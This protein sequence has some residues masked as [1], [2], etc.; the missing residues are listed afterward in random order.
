MA[1]EHWMYLC[2]GINITL[3]G[4]P[5]EAQSGGAACGGEQFA[6][7]DASRCVPAAW[8]CDM[9]PQCP[10]ASDEIGC[11]YNMTCGAGQFRCVR[12]GLCIAASWR[13]DGD[14]D[15]GPHDASDEDPYMCEKDFKCW[16]KWARCATPEDGHFNCVPVYHFCDGVRHCLDGSDEWD[17]CDNFTEASCASHGCS[18]CR[19]THEGVACYCQPGYEW[20]NG[21]CVDSDEC[22]WEGACSQRCTNLPGSYTC[23]CVDGYT[24]RDDKKSCAAINEP[25]G[26]PLSLVVATQSGVERAWPAGGAPRNRSLDALG[27]RALDFHF[28]NRTV[29]YIHHNISRSSLV[30]VDADNFNNRTVMPSPTLFPDLNSVSHL[31]VDWVANNWYFADEAREV[32]Y[33]CDASLRFCRMLLDAG[34]SKLRGLALDPA[35]GLMFWSV[36]GAAA[37]GVW[38]ATLGG[39]A[40]RSLAALKLVYPGALAVD[41]AARLLYWVDAYLESVERTDYDGGRR[42]TVRRSYVTQKLQQISVLESTLYLPV[43]SNSS[44]AAVSRYGR[45]RRRSSVP[46]RARPLAAL[47]YHRQRQPLVSHPCAAHKGGCAHVCVTA[48]R[49]DGRDGRDGRAPHAQCLCRHGFRLVGHGDCERV[50]SDSFLVVSRGAPALVSGLLL[51][52]RGALHD[53]P[54]APA[55]HAARP[56]VADVDLRDRT[57]YYCDVHRYE[58][59]RQKLD[60]S[61]REVFV[62]DDVDNCEGLAIDWMGRNVYWTDDALGQVSV[63][64][65]DAPA[66]RVLLREQNFNPR[67]IAL[68]P[69]NG[70][71]YWSVWASVQGARARLEVAAMDASR[72]RTLLDGE[73]HWPNGL[74]LL[75]PERVLYWCDTYL[76]KIER[77]LVTAA[78]ELAPGARREL[79]AHEKPDF[80]LFKPYGLAVYEDAVVWSEHGT[81]QVRRLRV[82][83]SVDTLRAFPPPLY[84]LRRVSAAAR[85]GANLCSQDNGGCAELC[86]A[87]GAGARRCACA[88]G[89]AL[90]PDGRACRAAPAATRAPAC[91]DKHFHCGHGRC[92]DSSFLCDGDADCPDGADEDASPTGPCANV[93]CKGDEFMQCGMRCIPK[94]WVCDGL[95]DCA[96]GADEAAGACARAACGAAQFACAR[97]RRCLPAAWRCDGAPD[98]GRHDDSDEAGCETESCG[99][100]SFRC[101]NGACV[102]WEFYCD[103]HA[104]CADASDERACPSTPATPPRRPAHAHRHNDTEKLGLCEDH[105][106]QCDNR[107]CI[108]KEFRCD[109]RVDCLDG[110]DE[111]SC[112]SAH[113][114]GAPAAG[115]AP[116]ADDCAAPALRCDNDS[117]CVP[118]LQLCDGRQD[119]ADGADEADRCELVLRQLI[120]HFKISEAQMGSWVELPLCLR[121]FRQTLPLITKGTCADVIRACLK[122]SP[123]WI[124]I[125]TLNLKTNMRAHL[126]ENYDSDFSQQLFELGEGKTSFPN[127]DCSTADIE[128]DG[129]LGRIIYTLEHLIDAI[130]PGLE[131]LLQKGYR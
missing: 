65:L 63:A 32:V 110:S 41:P 5:G 117:R 71:M 81:G 52:G 44:V 131:S 7:A 29:C 62:G 119:C 74:A 93:T 75:L 35:A 97:S 107:E 40:T 16:G 15:C 51:G 69:A 124:S 78:G 72:R 76:N 82:N 34:L 49:G 114:T 30:C 100:G 99:S 122:S 37:P 47:V 45:E 79:V 48:Y 94:S 121:D 12:S 90:A 96:D 64:R 95:K 86:L 129:R 14:A 111:W 92:I 116:R 115:S 88:E 123:L 39:D 20:R 120:K 50:E 70:V 11:T 46:M 67:S 126:S 3:L 127:T 104:D 9:R 2:Y 22:E 55:A 25:V 61:E 84:D 24:L 108:R 60:G 53:E 118:L 98:C 8:R 28:S 113:T 80:P 83:G 73:L 18:A 105:E 33:A 1:L 106:F 21:H 112:D 27:V 36:W 128:L 66:R 87:T 4:V 109:S 26:A 103:G 57:L 23:A 31:A 19:P 56:T 17:I 91:P 38:R 59:V 85:T 101:A 77:V 13:C 43:W 58:I 6:C 68:D 125:E 89:R 130:Y 102:P 10:D 54:F 42:L